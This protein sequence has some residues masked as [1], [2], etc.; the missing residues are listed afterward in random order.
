MRM[1]RAVR[2]IAI[3]VILCLNVGC[4]QLSKSIVRER[5]DYNDHIVVVKNYFTLMKV[6]NTGA[7]LSLGGTLPNPIKFLLLTLLPV[8]VLGF[9]VFY[10]LKKKDLSKVAILGLCFAMGG[11]IGNI[12]DRLMYSSVTDFMHIDFYIFQTGIFNMADVS[13]MIGIFL[14]ILE[15]TLNKKPKETIEADVESSTS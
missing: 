14:L 9:G 1:N 4:D 6:E 10:L 3:V 7:F 8:L 15:T 12:Y 11:G 5:L 2:M 13:I